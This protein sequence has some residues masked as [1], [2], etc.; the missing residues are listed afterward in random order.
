M[1]ASKWNCWIGLTILYV[2]YK[3]IAKKN[4]NS[5]LQFWI[6]S[7]ELGL[8]CISW[9]ISVSKSR[10]YKNMEPGH[11]LFRVHHPFSKTRFG[12]QNIKLR[13]SSAKNGWIGSQFGFCIKKIL[14]PKACWKISLK[15]VLLIA[16]K[17]QLKACPDIFK[18]F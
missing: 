1:A 14:I 2:G 8:H 11:I 5:S 12:L 7:L 16:V 3:K 9:T 15:I 4:C 18:R 13:L 6:D 10:L 17:V